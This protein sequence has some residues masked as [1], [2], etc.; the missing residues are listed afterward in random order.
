[1]ALHQPPAYFGMN[2]TSTIHSKAEGLT[3][4]INNQLPPKYVVVITG[5]GKGLGYNIALAYTKAGARFYLPNL[6]IA[7]ISLP[8]ISPAEY[9]F[10]LGRSQI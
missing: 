1:M 3:D 4:P 2:F 9:A 7:K 5:A 10:H 8:N 6:S